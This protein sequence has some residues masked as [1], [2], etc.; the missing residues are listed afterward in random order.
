MITRDVFFRVDGTAATG[1]GHVSRCLVLAS[2]LA[3][4][5]ARIHFLAARLDS[6]VEAMIA[7]AGHRVVRLAADDGLA[8]RKEI[9][10]SA[11]SR[12]LLVVDHYS[13]DAKWERL[14]RPAVGRLMVID[15]LADRPHDCDFILDQAY[16]EDGS[17]YRNLVPPGCVGLFGT[18]YALLRSE[19]AGLRSRPLKNL[20]RAGALLDVHVFFGSFDPRRLALRFAPLI[21][22]LE[23]VCNISISVSEGFNAREPLEDLRLQSNGRIRWRIPGADMASHMAACD[24]A[25]GAPGHTTWERA[26]LGLPAAYVAV[27]GNQVD[28]LKRLADTGLCAYLGDARALDDRQFLQGAKDFLADRGRLVRMRRLAMQAVDGEG[29]ARVSRA[30]LGSRVPS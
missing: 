19:F 6:D 2:S 3:Q 9:L 29:A 12:P 5:G 11:R 24:V 23:S 15:D 28:I 25:I 7:S 1:A 14:V 16:G 4:K 22:C 21:A 13:L 10:D 30:L 27:S 17:R 18:R 8:C 20:E 26:C